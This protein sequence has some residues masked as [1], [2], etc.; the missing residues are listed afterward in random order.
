MSDVSKVSRVSSAG[1]ELGRHWKSDFELDMRV[2]P[3]IVKLRLYGQKTE[4]RDFLPRILHIRTCIIY[5]D[6]SS[7]SFGLIL[8]EYLKFLG[9]T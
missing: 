3:R 5:T 7:R 4:R 9:I 1:R 8:D 6:T 2:S